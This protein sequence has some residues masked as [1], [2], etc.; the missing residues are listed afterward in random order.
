MN[1][2]SVSSER[3]LIA[4]L[5]AGI[6]HAVLI[7][8]VS[9]EMPKFEKVTQSLTIALVRNPSRE[10][11]EKADFLAQENQFGSGSS[12][13]KAIPRAQPMP[14][15]GTG[16]QAKPVPIPT[17]APTMETKPAPAPTP[18][19]EMAAK[20]KPV[21]KQEKSEKKVLDADGGTETNEESRPHRLDMDALS[22]QIA[23]LSAEIDRAREAAAKQPKIVY[24]NSINAHKHKAAAYERA[25]QDKIER[26]GNL[27]YPDE[28]RRQK[29]SG[30]LL[31]AVQ[32]N[33]DGSVRGIQVRHSSGHQVLDDAA[34][35]IVR[36]A[37]PFAPFP[38]D[39][40]QEADVLAI[41]RT[42]RFDNNS[43]MA[44]E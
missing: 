21:L 23:E 12:E 6:A 37:A 32:I 30:S 16:Q 3:F 29:I 24:I 44:T 7:L 41:T 35:R 9:F 19:R 22:Q 17:P 25:W 38:D 8:G 40:R 14:Q 28:A 39:L 34:V 42:W 10:A 18:V 20:R 26:I 13:K 2:D 15:E 43:R 33:Q 1:T 5:L 31:L 36:L 4:L 11:P 27:N